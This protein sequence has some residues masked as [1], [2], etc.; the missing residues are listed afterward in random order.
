M[1]ADQDAPPP[2]EETPPS[3]G[4][5]APRPSEDTVTPSPGEEATPPPEQEAPLPLEEEAPPPSGE[6]APPPPREATSADVPLSERGR[7][8]TA[9]DY[10]NLIP[11]DKRIILPDDDE[12]DPHR[13]RHRPTLRTAT[14][15]LS[16]ML[17]LSCPRSS[18][19]RR[20]LSGISNLQ[21]TLKE[22][23][24]R[25]RDARES[26]KM[27]IESSYKYIF[28]ILSEKLG[29]DLVTVEELILDCPSDLYTSLE[30][31]VP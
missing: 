26:R 4:E 3:L 8:R 27:K 12:P 14:L 31:A 11:S 21:E 7:V 28:E 24:A 18:K 17:S 9:S 15:A 10:L 22:R 25:F 1:S 2:L 13:I 23:Q 6:E 20:S 19:Y 5:G 16:E 29:L 30:L